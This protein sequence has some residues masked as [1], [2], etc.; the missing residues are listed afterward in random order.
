MTKLVGAASY[1]DAVL[2]RMAAH[3]AISSQGYC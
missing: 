2:L 1:F 3:S